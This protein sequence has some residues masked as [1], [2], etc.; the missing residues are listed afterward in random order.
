MSKNSEANIDTSDIPKY[1]NKYEHIPSLHNFCIEKYRK[2]NFN[3]VSKESPKTE[4]KRTTFYNIDFCDVDKRIELKDKI[5]NYLLEN[6]KNF[7][8]EKKDYTKS[9]INKEVIYYLD[10]ALQLD[11]DKEYLEHLILIYFSSMEK[12]ILLNIDWDNKKDKFIERVYLDFGYFRSD[13]AYKKNKGSLKK[14][15]KSKKSS[16]PNR[17]SLPK[18][19]GSLPK[20]SG[21]LPKRTG[22]L[23][24]R[25]GILPKRTSSL[26]KKAYSAPK[27][28]SLEE[29]SIIY[30]SLHTAWHIEDVVTFFDEYVMTYIHMKEEVIDNL[31]DFNTT[32][33]YWVT[34]IKKLQ[35]IQNVNIIN[36]DFVKKINKNNIVGVIIPKS[37]TSIGH[38]AF[39]AC[40]GMTSV[41]IPNGVTSIGDHAFFK[42]EGLTSITIPDGVTS[43]GKSTFLRCAELT[44]ISIPDSVTSIGV[45]AFNFCAKLTSIT[46]PDGVTSIGSSAFD[47]CAGLTSFTIPVG[48]TSIEDRTFA[49]CTGLTSITIPNSVVS[50]GKSSFCRCTG[51]TSIHLSNGM[52]SI[53]QGSFFGCTGLRYIIIPVGVNIIG[54]TF[55]NTTRVFRI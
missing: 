47:G 14:V 7:L 30:K 22:S 43:I 19:T 25:M 11:I 40:T 45:A 35:E 51:L 28:L 27:R 8:K 53:E 2:N 4:F 21:S 36:K 32:Y 33:G 29:E 50:I 41:I 24:N 49:E 1:C 54:G 44:S 37:V 48:V 18:R 34:E 13:L 3:V 5:F 9:E 23:P 26:T 6:K 20:R 17:G 31:D 12:D 52:I 38:R 10:L 15:I 55:A 46:I 16:L 42:C 39:R